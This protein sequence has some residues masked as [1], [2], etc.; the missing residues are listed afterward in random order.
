MKELITNIHNHSVYSDGSGT[1]EQIANAG[2]QSSI[3]VLFVTDHNVLVKGVDAYY[4]QGEKKILLLIGQEIHDRNRQPQRNHLL[5]IGHST[6]LSAFASKPQLLIDKARQAGGLTFLAHP[7]EDDLKMIHEPEISWV[8]WQVD[9]FHGMEIWNH[10]SELKTV[11][12][13]WYKLLFYVFFPHFYAHNPNPK[14]IQK[15]DSLTNSNSKVVAI[16][17]SD[18]H[19]LQMRKGLLKAVVFPYK[20]HFHCI[21]THIL[22]ADDL[23]G[24]LLTDRQIVLNAY[25]SGH[26][27]IGYDLPASTRGF[28]FTAQGN[29][30]TAIMGDEI[31][32]E[33]SITFQI[34]LPQPANCKLFRNGQVIKE[35]QSQ[36]IC[37]YIANQD[38]VYR[39]ECTIQ[40][41]GAKRTW[42]LSNPIYVKVAK[43]IDLV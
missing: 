21:N 18:G 30:V 41:L 3:D 36:E 1:Y 31:L 11:S 25:Q 13:N 42:I 23:S 37:S 33:S 14:T 6:E 8:D 35:W 12:P 38:G 19:A 7:F 27:F 26:A 10:F 40:Y 32:V 43:R 15:W 39:V 2:L 24:N 20:F 4:H 34:R 22:V 16:G 5:V 29:A 17:G 28:R 9:G